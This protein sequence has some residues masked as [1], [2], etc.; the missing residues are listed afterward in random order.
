MWRYLI[1]IWINDL[2]HA[3][4]LFVQNEIDE[5]HEVPN[6][7]FFMSPETSVWGGVLRDLSST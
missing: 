7:L 2:I 6:S 5:R 4:E 1:W 3:D